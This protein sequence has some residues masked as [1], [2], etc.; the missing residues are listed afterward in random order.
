M[1]KDEIKK[2]INN[3]NKKLMS[4]IYQIMAQIMC[5]RQPY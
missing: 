2:K 3:N 4:I 1:L 5:L